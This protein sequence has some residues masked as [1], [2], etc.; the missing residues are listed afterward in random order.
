MYLR[1]AS[2]P[3][4][5]Y[6]DKNS[7]LKDPL[8][9]TD[10]TR[11]PSEEGIPILASILLSV[12]FSRSSPASPPS[13]P[14]P[15]LSEL[16][17]SSSRDSEDEG[18]EDDES[19]VDTCIEMLSISAALLEGLTLDRDVNKQTLA[20]TK[21]PV[22]SASSSRTLLYELLDF[23]EYA[24]PPT[25]WAK[26]SAERQRLDK[27]FEVVKAATVRAVVEAMN[28]DDVMHAMWKNSSTPNPLV[29]KL[30]EWLD[31]DNTNS[32]DLMVC[33][34]HMLAGLGRSGENLPS[35][36][37]SRRIQT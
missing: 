6:V 35:L 31:R 36:R 7:G 21:Y 37:R 3:L 32:Q 17:V 22:S 30:V 20:L 29:E 24:S 10:N 5:E 15:S 11:F 4:L 34:S 12:P 26:T 33:G 9:L 19:H 8:S 16:S 25:A 1:K 2:C 14:V 18:D 13:D 23:I 27:T 28:D